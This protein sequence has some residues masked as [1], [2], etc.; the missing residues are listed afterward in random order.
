MKA[1]ILAGGFGTRLSEATHLIPKPMVEI[2]G[3]PILWH[4]MK[5]YSEH[6]INE[7]VI[8][9]GYKGYIIKEWFANYFLH[10][11]DVT[12]DLKNN[13]LEVHN[14]N[15]EDWKVTL[16]DTGLNTMTGGRI[17][18]IQKYIGNETFLL[19]YGD[20]VSNI[21]ITK[22]IEKHKVKGKALTVTA[23]KPQGKFGSLELN[24]T[25]DVDSFT[26]KPAG[27][28]MWINAGYFVC[29]PEVFDYITEGDETIFER[30]PLENL[31][32]D[33]KMTSFKHTGFWKPMDILRD[34]KELNEMW[35]KGSAPWK[36]WKD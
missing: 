11:S 15:A 6:G 20:G 22:A 8:C 4:I 24:E 26:E 25:G 17:K 14:T 29:E 27:D 1:V 36:I 35:D 7:F 32:K 3:K 30:A 5:T 19:T 34:N 2:G 33:G 28:G 21:D 10:T 18:R 23:Y 13:S 12:I 16:V 9:C 31:A